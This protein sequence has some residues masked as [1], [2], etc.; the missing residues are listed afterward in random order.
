MMQPSGTSAIMAKRIAHS[1]ALISIAC[2]RSSIVRVAAD[3]NRALVRGCLISE[4]PQNDSLD[5][6]AARRGHQRCL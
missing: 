3:L 2:P 6:N 4:P 1:A 5:V